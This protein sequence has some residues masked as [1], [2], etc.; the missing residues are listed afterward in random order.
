MG[1]FPHDRDI[2]ARSGSCKC[3][4]IAERAGTGP[5]FP[6]CLCFPFLGRR[7]H[8]AL[9]SGSRTFQVAAAA[10]EP[11]LAWPKLASGVPHYCLCSACSGEGPWPELASGVPHNCLF[12]AW[13]FC[14]TRL[15][16]D[17]PPTP[18]SSWDGLV[19]VD[20]CIFRVPEVA[21]LCEDS[22]WRARRRF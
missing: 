3:T 12:P 8:G 22:G 6:L 16:L 15:L 17:P 13:S 9:T 20:L 5:R 14:S 11:C 21:A 1:V 10:D 4:A 18:A 7:G 19:A 2:R